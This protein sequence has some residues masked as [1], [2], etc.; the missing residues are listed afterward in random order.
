M[1]KTLFILT[2]SLLA[3][4]SSIGQNF[5]FHLADS[6]PSSAKVDLKSN[7]DSEI[8]NI[9]FTKDA[10]AYSDSE[11][12]YM[13]L[14]VKKSSKAQ[15]EGDIN[16]YLNNGEVLIL[17][18]EY[19]DYLDKT[20]FSMYSLDDDEL[21]QLK[22]SSIN[23]IQ[24]TISVKSAENEDDT[25]IEEKYSASVNGFSTQTLVAKFFTRSIEM[26]EEKDKV[27]LK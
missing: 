11:K 1:K 25:N 3:S 14:S 23:T 4:I 6:Y 12:K 17:E 27:N 5:F 18:P 24:Y 7:N 9:F 26:M 20:S 15:I 10:V 21:A 8:V 13:V 16:V 22:T 19:Q 2:T